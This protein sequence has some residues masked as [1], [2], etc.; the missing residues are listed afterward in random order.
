MLSECVLANFLGL[1]FLVNRQLKWFWTKPKK[2]KKNIGSMSLF[3]KVT[4]P[5]T[6]GRNKI[7]VPF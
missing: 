1:K 6:H 4:I 7:F 2:I 5:G 3:I